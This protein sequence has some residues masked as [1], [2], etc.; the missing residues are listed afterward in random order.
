MPFNL[1]K[2]CPLLLLLAVSGSPQ[3]AEVSI[4]DAWIRALPPTQPVTAAY[5]QLRNG[6]GEPVVVTGGSAEGVGRVEIHTTRSEGGLT[7]MEQLTTLTV[8]PGESLDLA[9][10]GTHLMLM[11]LSGMPRAGEHRRLCL[12]LDSGGEVCTRAEVRKSAGGT[13]HVHHH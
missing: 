4:H 8:P 12:Q 6:G 10:G 9:P 1:K 13:D 5:L 7:R 11:E 2:R 3:A